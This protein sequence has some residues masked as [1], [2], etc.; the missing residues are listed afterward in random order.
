MSHVY[1]QALC[2]VTLTSA[3]MLRNDLCSGLLTRRLQIW[4]SEVRILSGAPLSYF[5]HLEPLVDTLDRVVRHTRVT[6]RVSRLGT[7]VLP[8]IAI[9]GT[10]RHTPK[11]GMRSDPTT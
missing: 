11:L 9:M 6:L 1:D 5:K 8:A 2:P 7:V 4:G 10:I 3:D